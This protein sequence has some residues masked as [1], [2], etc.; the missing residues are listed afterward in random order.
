MWLD[1]ALGGGKPVQDSCQMSK[2]TA[3]SPG[4]MTAGENFSG[5]GALQRN[6]GITD[7]GQSLQDAQ[8]PSNGKYEHAAKK[9]FHAP[10]VPMRLCFRDS[11][12]PPIRF[13]VSLMKQWGALRKS[14]RKG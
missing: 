5:K 9:K 10:I 6:Y 7:I 8:P 14:V 1:I 4:K 3:Y 12:G 2:R 11:C 13:P